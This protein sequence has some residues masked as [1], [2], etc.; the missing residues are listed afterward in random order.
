MTIFDKKKFLF[1]EIKLIRIQ[2]A[3]NHCFEL[4]SSQSTP[5]NRKNQ[6]SPTSSTN[7]NNTLETHLLF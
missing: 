6:P 7:H 4:H 3:L 5:N 2:K 1:F